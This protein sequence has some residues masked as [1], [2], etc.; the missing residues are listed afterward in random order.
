MNMS[1]SVK[2]GKTNLYLTGLLQVCTIMEIKITG[3]NTIIGFLPV[4]REGMK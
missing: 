1:P 2:E 3:R 4:Y